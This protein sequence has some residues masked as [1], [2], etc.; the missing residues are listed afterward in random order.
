MRTDRNQYYGTSV[1]KWWHYANIRSSG[2][3]NYIDG[4]EV[5]SVGYDKLS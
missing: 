4:V 1:G 2:T 3:T 5:G